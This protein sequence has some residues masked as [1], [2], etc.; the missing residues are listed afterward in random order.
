MVRRY[1]QH[2]K[3]Q[4]QQQQHD[5]RARNY[6][7]CW[8]PDQAQSQQHN[9]QGPILWMILLAGLSFCLINFT[10][11]FFATHMQSTIPSFFNQQ[12][13]SDLLHVLTPVE[14]AN[15]KLQ[16]QSALNVGDKEPILQILKDAGVHDAVTP[17]ILA[18]LPT[19]QDVVNKLG[20][21]PR[22][23]GLDSC[24]TFRTTIPP[25]EAVI[26][27]A[28]AFNSGTN[29]MASL[30]IANCHN[31]ARRKQYH[32]DGVRWQVSWGK[33]QPPKFRAD[34]AV[35]ENLGDASANENILPVVT[36]RDPY[37]WLQ[38]LCRNR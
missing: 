35:Y 20:P 5:K 37:T 23:F 1:I 38:S 17:A 27:P 33:H 6:C 12:H 21:E 16:T 8:R 26:A 30:L 13:Q 4:Q 19:W 22:I 9:H 36:I 24:Q 3:Q 18:Q 10:Y 32:S 15:P 2:A 28:G 25:A 14:R 29:L 7:P 11:M 34:Q 31:P